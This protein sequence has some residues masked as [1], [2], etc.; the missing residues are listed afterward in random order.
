[1][2]YYINKVNL[3]SLKCFSSVVLK[4]YSQSNKQTFSFFRFGFKSL[5]EIDC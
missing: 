4:W 1:M 2:F 5:N 3:K